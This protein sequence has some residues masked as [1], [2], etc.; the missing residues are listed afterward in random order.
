M[1]KRS[2]TALALLI[3]ASL[4]GCG[5]SYPEEARRYHAVAQEVLIAKG[6][7]AGP[8]DCQRKEIL[9]WEGGNPWLPGHNNAYVTLYETNDI[10]LVEAIVARLKQAKAETSMPPVKLVVYSSTHR[11]SKVTFR[12][13]TIQ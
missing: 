10:A 3:A 4:S 11:Q 12:E 1:P 6:A 13:V 2:S 9:F 8:Q 7:C 5:E